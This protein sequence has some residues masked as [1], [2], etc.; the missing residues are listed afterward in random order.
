MLAF[1]AGHALAAT[2]EVDD[3]KVECKKAPFT[4]IQAAVTAATPGDSIKVCPGTY[5]EQVRITK[6]NLKLESRNPQAATI[7]APPVMTSP[8]AIVYIDG[9]TGVTVRDF[10]ISG[11]GGGP[12]DSLE[13]GVLVG[14]SAS[15]PSTGA[16]I[17]HN[18]ITRI[19]DN[20]AGGCQ[21]GNA[22]QVGRDFVGLVGSADVVDN[23][24]DAYQKTGVVVDGTGS[25][26][27]VRD[28]TITGLGSVSFIAQNG[29]QVSRSAL[30]DV[31]H[32]TISDN[33]YAPQTVASTGVLVFDA[34]P[35][36]E[37]SHNTILRNDEGVYLDG[38][39]GGTVSHNESSHN[40]FD[41]FGVIDATNMTVDH[42][43]AEGNGFDGV[44]A[45]ADSS[46]N[47][48]AFNHL[49]DNAEHDCH[50]DSNGPYAPGVANHWFNNKGVTENK[51]G[52][53]QGEKP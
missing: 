17:R 41:G 37:I 35:A 46:E 11:P 32:N 43:V 7:K 21:N 19:Q 27:R 28:N 48:I 15:D 50:D 18:R 51:P 52:L 1:G 45:T 10:V 42:N 31:E 29:V 8:K 20:P 40:T 33:L 24:I 23:T 13:Y 16:E 44:Y 39:D 53:C 6:D 25:S 36:S 5:N 26:A 34:N 47:S 30:A 12:C 49:S 9:A 14:G 2:I 4:S 22:V 38:Q 3:N